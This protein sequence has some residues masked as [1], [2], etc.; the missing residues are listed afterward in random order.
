MTK[1]A[2]IVFEVE[3]EDNDT[4][5]QIEEKMYDHMSGYLSDTYLT[6]GD[7]EISDTPYTKE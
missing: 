5:V 3:I 6:V 4:D 1:Y 2:R 7:M